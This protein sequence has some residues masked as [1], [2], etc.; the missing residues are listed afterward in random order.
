MRPRE[1]LMHTMWRELE[2][3]RAVTMKIDGQRISQAEIRD[4]I[5]CFV[6]ELESIF[7]L[8]NKS[9]GNLFSGTVQIGLPQQG[10]K[11]CITYLKV[12]CHALNSI[13]S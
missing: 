6:I 5:M 7:G 3:A 12:I 10:L 2:D 13:V 9:A 11:Q 1:G 4:G 8:K